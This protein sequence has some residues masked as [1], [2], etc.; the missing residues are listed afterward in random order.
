MSDARSTQIRQPGGPELDAPSVANMP[1]AADLPTTARLA[2]LIINPMAFQGHGSDDIV[3]AATHELE[4]VGYQVEVIPTTE[5]DHGHGIAHQAVHDGVAMVVAAGGDGTIHEVAAGLVGSDVI[6]GI[7]P[8]GTMNNVALSVGIPADP[9]AAIQVLTHGKPRQI[10]VGIANG[11]PFMEA[12]SVGLEAPLFPLGEAMRHHGVRGLIQG[13]FG[14]MQLINHSQSQVVTLTLDGKKR[15]IRVRQI[16]ISNTPYYGLG[17]RSGKEASISDGRLDVVTM[18]YSRR[19]DLLLHYWAIA[20]GQL[21]MR[22]HTHLRQARSVRIRVYPPMPVAIDGE[23]AGTTPINIAIKAGALR[24]MAPPIDEAE[25]QQTVAPIQ[26]LWRAI[27]PSADA[28][29]PN[30]TYAP[31]EI[32]HRWGTLAIFTWIATVVSGA[33]TFLAYRLRWWPFWHEARPARAAVYHPLRDR[34]V[35]RGTLAT[36]IAAFIRLGLPLE[37]V[38]TSLAGGSRWVARGVQALF[39]K[40]PTPETRAMRAVAASGVLAAGIWTSRRP[41]WRR[42]ALLAGLGVLAAWFGGTQPPVAENRERQ[43]ESRALGF[44]IG[45]TWLSL[46]ISLLTA[47]QRV[48]LHLTQRP[49]HLERHTSPHDARTPTPPPTNPSMNMAMV[50]VAVMEPLQRGDVVLFGPDGTIGSRMIEIATLS[51]FHHVAIYDGEGMV[52]EAMPHGVRRYLLGNR[53]VT[54]IRP[55]VADAQRTAAADWARD[56]I[57]KPYDTRGLA[58]IAFDR[59]L[60]GLRLGNASA[61][62]FSCAVFVADAYTHAGV[63]L[64]PG[65][66]WE[67]LVPGDYI[68]L[69]DSPPVA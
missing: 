52:I 10:D 27:L 37:A 20:T 59:L 61:N 11:H 68:H 46:L 18:R 62:R 6:L 25:R 4:E 65:E 32:A 45:A 8:L 38:A 50:P 33:L 13:L 14:A 49:S 58:L 7:L 3:T 1:T 34:W 12:V 36:L 44:V 39:P 5:Q 47:A 55:R 48:L 17:I 63:D 54:G 30:H 43:H 15:Q 66:R 60:P 42:G 29:D 40:A 51:Y 67:D 22:Q 69:L 28:Q 2:R 16:T 41:S 31:E 26:R 9:F 57:G 23:A 19:R 35:W 64:L 21:E 24:L 53:R 56:Q